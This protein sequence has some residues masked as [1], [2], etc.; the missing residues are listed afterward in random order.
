M[1]ETLAELIVK[2]RADTQELQSSLKSAEG[3]LDDF[4]REANKNAASMRKAMVGAAV[5]IGA[6]VIASVKAYADLGSTIHDMAAI[7]GFGT[8]AISELKYAAEQSGS[9]LGGLQV[10]IRTMA[11]AITSAD[12]GMATYIRSFERIGIKVE[13]L[14]GLKPEGQFMKIASA[15]ASLEDATLRAATAQDI[16]GR[17]GTGLLPL[18]AEGAEGIAKLRQE[19]HDL[20]IVFSPEMADKADKLGDSFTKLQGAIKG[21]QISIG[22]AAA[23]AA[24]SLADFITGSKNLTDLWSESWFSLKM[25]IRDFFETDVEQKLREQASAGLDYSRSLSEISNSTNAATNATG[26][27]NQVIATS[28]TVIDGALITNNLY[29]ESEIDMAEASGLLIERIPTMADKVREFESSLKDLEKQQK[30]NAEAADQIN[31]SFAS[32]MAQIQYTGSDAE[33]FNITMFDVYDAMA[34]LGFSTDD[35]RAKWNIWGEDI[36]YIEA[37]L[38]ALGKTA[39]DVSKI[40]SDG[41]NGAGGDWWSVDTPPVGSPPIP[42]TGMSQDYAKI[43]SD[44]EEGL[45]TPAQFLPFFEQGLREGYANFPGINIQEEVARFMRT[46]GLAEGGIV[47][48][49]T[50]AMIGEAGPEAVVPLNEVMGGITINFTQPVFFDREDTMNRFVDMISKGIDRKYRLNGRL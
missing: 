35:I 37:A 3:K 9:S 17:S 14:K 10:A 50:L 6:A 4:E 2:I 32:M 46:H 34:A 7:T 1:A 13:D 49:P 43:W 41:A 8:E 18:F 45:L 23:P 11:G 5:A 22:E 25:S 16:F 36:K 42:G 28:K 27:Q 38:A 44:F 20:G 19:A 24:E 31:K 12:E 15:I 47:T 40:L 21:V 30:K 33:K 29:T 48:Q 39:E 26:E